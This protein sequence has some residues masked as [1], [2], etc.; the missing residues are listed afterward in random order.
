MERT[1]NA[2]VIKVEG[3][4]VRRVSDM[5]VH[6]HRVV[7]RVGERE[8][9]DTVCTPG[10]E[11]ELAYGHLISEGWV[12]SVNDVTS[13]SVAPDLST[14][15][16]QLHEGHDPLQLEPQSVETTY[17]VSISDVSKAAKGAEAQCGVFRATGGT[18]LAGV[19]PAGGPSVIAED[20]S[21]TCAL[22]KA[23][24]EALLAWV[25]LDRSILFI[26][27]RVPRQF[28]Q[29]VARVGIP[30]IAAVS[31]PTYEA[32]EEAERLGICLCGFV[33]GNRLNVYSQPWRV[34]LS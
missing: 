20:I 22:E 24:G 25:D 9:L 3:L 8:I 13:V 29:K 33:R 23:L 15:S 17:A 4:E 7:I 32:A 10:G 30:I 34:G 21:R 26:T 31:A 11:R 28:V 16:I 2:T 19:V 5:L 27:S 1:R 18:H 6:E 12:R 14:V